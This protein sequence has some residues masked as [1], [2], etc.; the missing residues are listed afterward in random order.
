MASA[1]APTR[2]PGSV[3][4]TA[5]AAVAPAADPMDRDRLWGAVPGGAGWT[6]DRRNGDCRTRDRIHDHA[7]DRLNARRNDRLTVLIGQRSDRLAA[8]PER[9]NDQLAVLSDR[10]ND[11]LTALTD[12]LNDRPTAVTDR[13]CGPREQWL[14]R[15]RFPGARA[16]SQAN[17]CIAQHYP[18]RQVGIAKRQVHSA[19]DHG[20]RVQGC[21]GAGCRVQRCTP[22][23]APMH[24]CT[25]APLHLF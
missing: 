15:K 1:S 17:R 5:G 4:T 24:S 6:A 10:R 18:C 7:S 22:H 11:H 16:G 8:L 19:P 14:E 13:R 20:A 9:R 12:Q 2:A 23:K 25:V 3:P 21:K